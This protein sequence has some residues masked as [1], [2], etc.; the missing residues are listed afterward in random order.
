MGVLNWARLGHWFAHYW[1]VILIV[2]GII[3][4]IEYQTAQR[5]GTR[6]SGLGA[7][8]VFLL[9]MVIVAGLIATQA[10]RVDW[11]EM[12]DQIDIDDSDF[13]LFGQKYSYEDQLKQD[14]PA[15]SSLHVPISAARS[16]SAASEDNQIRVSVHKR[17][18]A[19][20]QSDAD[21]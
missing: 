21:K 19:E 17:I 10:S 3:K 8:G 5:E 9:I 14:F 15:G 16:T 20:S 2:A 6:A 7:G 13:T 18:N 11:G 4:L 12:R 1:P